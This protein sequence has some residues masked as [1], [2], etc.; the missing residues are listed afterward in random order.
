[1]GTECPV[2][3]CRYEYY[4]GHSSLAEIDHI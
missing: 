3:Y 4:T 2:D 1:V